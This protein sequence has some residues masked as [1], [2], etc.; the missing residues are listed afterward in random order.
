MENRTPSRSSAARSSGEL[1]ISPLKTIHSVPGVVGHRLMPA[2]EIQDAQT[3][4]PER[5]RRRL[6]HEHAGV[7]GAAV[8]L[9]RDHGVNP[10]R[11][12]ASGDARYPA[13]GVT[14]RS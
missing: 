7:V 8:H 2:L 4:H 3:P 13:H 6:V 14:T 11:H 10:L 12:A 9:S 5:D 1:K